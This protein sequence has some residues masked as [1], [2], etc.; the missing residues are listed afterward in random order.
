MEL[1]GGCSAEGRSEQG[2]MML[3]SAFCRWDSEYSAKNPWRVVSWMAAENKR[4]LPR[5]KTPWMKGG[6][7]VSRGAVHEVRAWPIR[8][9]GYVSRQAAKAAAE[10]EG[11]GV[12][13]MSGCASSVS[14]SKTFLTAGPFFLT[15]HPCHPPC[16]IYSVM[17]SGSRS[18]PAPLVDCPHRCP[19]FITILATDSR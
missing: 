1:V 18:L 16:L 6:G 17:L 12:W 19:Y 3:S 10:C 8:R 14:R 9:D 13:R 4:R 11:V 2:Q 5:D 7:L 15:A